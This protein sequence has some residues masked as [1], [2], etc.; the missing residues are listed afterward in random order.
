MLPF[1]TGLDNSSIRVLSFGYDGNP[2]FPWN[3]ANTN[4]IG[5]L[6]LD[7]LGDLGTKRHASDVVSVLKQTNCH[8]RSDE[9]LTLFQNNSAQ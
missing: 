2:F 3:P 6:A 5:D 8:R 7:L 4:T 9:N 1:Y